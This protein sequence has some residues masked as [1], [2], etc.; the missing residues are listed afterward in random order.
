MKQSLEQLSI[1]TIR[2]LSID[3][4]EK[5]NSGHP[6]LPMGAAPMAY[7]LWAKVMRHNSEDPNWFDRDRFVLS[8][9]HGSMLLYSLLHLFGYGLTIEDLK[10]FRQWH[11]LT[12]GHP[13]Y[14][15]TAGVEA[16]TG[17][18]GQGI[19]MAVG[20]AMAE[21]HL[22]AKYNKDAFDIVNHYTYA[23]CGDG[24][25]M[26]GITGEAASLAGHLK[27][28]KLIVLYDS[29]DISLDGNLTMSFSEN[30]RDRFK[31]YGWQTFFVNDGNC[32]DEIENALNTAKRDKSRPT[33]IEVKT[34]IGFGAPHVQGTNK[35]HGN[36]L[37]E[38]ELFETKRNY[39]W[40]HEPFFVPEEVKQHFIALA[41]KGKKEQKLWKEKYE[42]YKKENRDLAKELQAAVHGNLPISYDAKL[43]EYEVGTKKATRQTSGEI[44]NVLS[45]RIPQLFGGAADLSS[46]TKTN[47]NKK[48]DFTSDNYSGQN[49]WFGVREFGM[50]AAVNGMALHGG[51][52]PFCST[53]FTFS[54]YAK[55]AIR[56]AALMGIPSIFV[57]THDSIAVGEDGPTHEPIEQLAGL[58]S[59]PNLT[60]IRP[61]DGN[62]VREA[63]KIAVE[64]Q[65]R[66]T[67]LVLTR[68]SVE[69]VPRELS[70][71]KEGVRR[72][73]YIVSDSPGRDQGVLI[74]TGSEVALAVKAQ[75]LLN[76]RDISV[77]VVSMP[78]WELFL[79]QPKSYQQKIIPPNIAARVSIEMAS[80]TGWR[81]FTGDK[82]TVI[83]IDCFGSSA[84]SERLLNEYQFTAEHVAEAMEAL[85][86]H[87]A[88]I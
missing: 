47:M 22:A 80:S 52:I 50:T 35:V 25:L 60:V 13:E 8:A 9:G 31:A 11:S 32:V 68:Q 42:N 64:S 70:R 59:I 65:H 36:P 30:V 15:H 24:D 72:G 76:E 78:S 56:L 62:E 39:E 28:G 51:I 16:T 18:L 41:E 4:I 5:A 33:L 2:T 27:L 73:A 34:T 69:T 46:S 48:G 7:T 81:R 57:Y 44:I 63:W 43:P 82:G 74:A 54:D 83:A 66:P 61:A 37:G 71:A 75:E 88:H 23:L 86:Q 40:D 20:M 12:P 77:R 58:R 29:N 84:P 14:G 85:R 45:E 67:V 19:A 26:E 49:I 10:Q 3:A 55:P 53:F 17:P 79:Q 38:E 87:L 21:T 1:N 6:G